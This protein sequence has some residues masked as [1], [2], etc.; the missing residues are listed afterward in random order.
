MINTTLINFIDK[1]EISRTCFDWCKEAHFA[2]NSNLE[3]GGI[4]IIIL[5]LV[6]LFIHLILYRF[7]DNIIKFVN[8]SDSDL[9]ISETQVS[10]A[11]IF[12]SEFA[13]YLLIGF[14]I[15]Y[16]YFA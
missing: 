16:L 15:W 2:H 9:N 3:I 13:M 1:P 12:L 14:M 10:S 6:A 5:A 8:N 4:F 7:S 11:I